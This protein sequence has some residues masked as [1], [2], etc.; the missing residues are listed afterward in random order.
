MSLPRQALQQATLPPLWRRPAPGHNAPSVP[1]L[2]SSRA[3]A[4]IVSLYPPSTI[5]PV[6]AVASVPQKMSVS[7]A[8]VFSAARTHVCDTT[9]RAKGQALRKAAVPWTRTGARLPARRTRALARTAALFGFGK[10]E[11]APKASPPAADTSGPLLIPFTPIQKTADYSLRLYS[12][13][14]VAECSYERRDEGFLMLG[15]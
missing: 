9:D 1:P 8:S 11:P 6:L 10:A 7:C 14:A 5:S 3:T 15:S 4:C 13:Y 12:A 2:F